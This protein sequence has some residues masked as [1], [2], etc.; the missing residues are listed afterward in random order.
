MIADTNANAPGKVRR[1]GTLTA[2]DSRPSNTNINPHGQ[3]S[4]AGDLLFATSGGG[5]TNVRPTSGRSVKVAYS[6]EGSK[7]GDVLLAYPLEN[8]VW[9]TAASGEDVVLRVG[10]SAGPD[11][12]SVRNYTNIEVASVNS[13]GKGSFNGATMQSQEYLFSC[14]SGRRTGC[15]YEKL[16]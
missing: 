12:V 14:R 4:A 9:V 5:L 15:R 2:V 11:K 6:L 13:L 1:A 3:T 8:P 7:N 10:D 16:C